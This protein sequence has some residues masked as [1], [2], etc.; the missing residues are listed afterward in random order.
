MS[1]L[2]T[3]QMSKNWKFKD[4]IDTMSETRPQTGYDLYDWRNLNKSR[5]KTQTLSKPRGSR[6]RIDVPTQR[7][8]PEL[9]FDKIEWEKVKKVWDGKEEGR[10]WASCRIIGENFTRILTDGVGSETRVVSLKVE[11][12][13]TSVRVVL[14]VHVRNA[15]TYTMYVRNERSHEICMLKDGCVVTR[16]RMNMFSLFYVLNRNISETTKPRWRINNTAR[17]FFRWSIEKMK[18]F[19][20]HFCDVTKINLSEFCFNIFQD[21]IQKKIINCYVKNWIRKK[22]N[23]K[24]DYN[25]K[26]I[27][28][29]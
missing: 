17:S 1:T 26:P 8:P 18:V 19:L 10:R 14:K 25:N 6:K 21:V 28:H 22:I 15:E 13:I 4:L 3:F 24:S 23:F 11:K 12:D 20:L 7:R 9:K 5:K 29:T 16:T 27:N 2:R